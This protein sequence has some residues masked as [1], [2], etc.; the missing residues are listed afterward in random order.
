M[1]IRP[2]KKL[3]YLTKT[4]PIFLF[5]I[6]LSFF[7]C[8]DETLVPIIN[9]DSFSNGVFI[10]NEGL[11]QAGNASV[12]F[13][14]LTTN[15][16]QERIFSAVN[17]QPLGDI[18]QSMNVQGDK[19]YLVVNNSDKIE[20]VNT[21]DFSSVGTI[22]NL[23]SPRHIQLINTDKAYVTDLFNEAISV[24]DLNTNQVI[25][26]IP[27]RGGSTEEMLLIG[28]ELFVTSPSLFNNYSNQLFVINTVSDEVVDSITV[29]YNPSN[30][31]LDRNNQ[32]W[33]M[34]NGDR[35][36]ADNFGGL[37]RINPD[38]K[39]VDLALPF[40]D[41]AASFYPRLA[42]N[43]NRDQ[44]YFLKLDIFSLSINDT[45]LPTNPII[46]ANGRDLYGLGVHPTTDQIFVGD[47]GN[48][49]QQ[50]TVTIHNEA[51]AELS[52][53]KAG[54]GVNGFYFN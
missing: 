18:L 40:T 44:L 3:W 9:D 27:I 21:S 22:E 54:V 51:G 29:G 43:G 8:S 39:A 1:N 38:T 36:V 52:T 14:D 13:Y 32:L 10:T 42:L 12:S 34:C 25:Q 50:G 31:Q 26:K 35:D 30:V 2:L 23:G 48:F 33:V 49:V 45:V 41:K 20:I 24:V 7:S 4:L 19:T 15:S 6:L 53:F 11:F 16:I 5:I 17:N 37:Y 47:S 46:E 28:D